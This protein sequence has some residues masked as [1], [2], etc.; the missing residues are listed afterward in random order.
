[1]TL[2]FL[3]GD[4]TAMKHYL[5]RGF[6]CLLA[7]LLLIPVLAPG[8]VRAKGPPARVVI[9]GPGLA[10]PLDVRGLVVGTLG[11]YS[12]DDERH[13]LRTAPRHLGPCYTVTRYDIDGTT[14]QYV[15]WDHVRYYP[16]PTGGRGYVYYIGLVS[17]SGAESEFD[18][19]W[20]QAGARGERALRAILVEHGVHL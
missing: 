17:D 1:M 19:R 2:W 15:A 14:R 20:F 18:G 9:S 7:L 10:R 8:L 3:E 13:L 12:L 11:W 6:S 4:S 16:S 5:H